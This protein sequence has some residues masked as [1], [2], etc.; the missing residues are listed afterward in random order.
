MPARFRDFSGVRI[1]EHFI[2]EPEVIFDFDN[3]WHCAMKLHVGMSKADL[4]DELR[5][6]ADLIVDRH[7]YEESKK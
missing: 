1:A 7:L 2:K 3:D 4:A 5:I 6:M